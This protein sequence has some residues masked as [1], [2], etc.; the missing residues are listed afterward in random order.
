MGHDVVLEAVGVRD[1]GAGVELGVVDELVHAPEAA[2]EG[3]EHPGG[4]RSALGEAAGDETSSEEHVLLLL[5]I[6]C[7]V[8][9]V[10]EKRFEKLQ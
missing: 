4:V 6:M 5:A 7:L 2:P 9:I 1:E 8:W 3:D 10:G